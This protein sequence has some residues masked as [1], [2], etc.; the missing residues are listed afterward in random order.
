MTVL[1][2]LP[3]RVGRA[4]LLGVVVSIAVTLL[5]RVGV[6]AGWEL[7]AV[8]TFLFMRARQPEPEIVL[9]AIDDAAFDG[10][11][12]RQPLPRDYVAEIVAFL[13]RAGARVIAVDLVVRTPTE[14][15]AD[16]ALV[17]VS[18]RAAA[19]NGSRLVFAAIARPASGQG[20]ERFELSPAFSPALRAGFGFSNTP[21]G[22]DGMIRRM[23]PVLPAADGSLLPSFA[24]AALAGRAASSTALEAALRL[25]DDGLRLP[26]RP[27]G[28]DRALTEEPIARAALAD[29]T[30][31]VDFTGPPGS[32]TAFPS[33]V[34]VQMAR[35]GVDPPA[36]N[37][38]RGKIVLVG[39]TFAESRD[40][41]PT[42]VGLMAGVEIQAHMIHTL[43]SRRVLMPPH[44]AARLALLLG[45]CVAVALL[46]LWLRP[47]WLAVASLA[48]LALLT[49]ASY[50]A[51]VR[52]GYWLDC[53]GPVVAMVGYTQVSRVLERRRI[54]S[55]FGQYVSAEVLDRVVAEGSR[56]GGELRRVSVLMSDVRGFTTLSERLSPAEI[57]VIMNEYF[58]AMVD[59]IM[60]HRGMVN[61]FIGD[62]IL[63]LF[64]APLD[65]PDH[66]GHAVAAALGMQAALRRLNATWA[67]AARPTLAMGVAVNTGE[68]FVGN[69]GSARKK[70]YSVLGDTVNTVA[71]IEGRNRE[72]GTEILISAGT[73][74]TVQGRVLVRD[75]GEVMLKGKAQPVAIF[76][77]LEGSAGGKT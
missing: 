43:L 44:W 58:A 73:L 56:L 32:V 63:A 72:L 29:A 27:V 15:A 21:V 36:D 22:A 45:V 62:G 76:E 7:R 77:L 55:A 6:L 34:L 16:A 14:P 49:L 53:V 65:D 54:R 40:F 46:S 57:S 71:R 38:F 60:E 8:D 51:F 17:A 42:P 5:S 3:A 37:P 30:W 41:Y 59:V 39:A 31:R 11:G 74:A 24:L 70:K 33:T 13:L 2:R 4:L 18:E 10:L 1:H 12:A 61:D 64:G 25:G 66:G 69:M 50:E 68:A 52:R 28:G 9:V 26:A 47:L 35:N 48:L 19:D 20:G 67:A 23:T 75:R